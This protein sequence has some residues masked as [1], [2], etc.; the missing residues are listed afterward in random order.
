M[1]S[2]VPLKSGLVVPAES[3]IEGGDQPA[4]RPEFREIATTR[5]GRDIT[6]G[7]VDSLPILPP[8][9]RVLQVRGG[10]SY[11]LY[12]EVLRD[13]QVASTFNQRGLA[14]VSREWEV[15]PGGDRPIDIAAADF[16]EETLK[17]IR[18]DA[19]TRKMLFGIFYGFAVG[20]C[21]WARDGRFVVLDEIKVRKQRRFAFTPESELRLLT[22]SN[23]F[24]E[25][26]PPRKFWAFATGSDNDDDPYGLGLAHWLYWPVFFKR[27]GI[28]FW[29]IF[30]EKFGQPTA[31][32]KYQGSA[33]A[34]EKTRLLQA[35][36][37]IM[38]D[39]GIT[40]PD[41]MAIELLEAAR[42][43]TADY[44]SLYDRMNAAI[45]KVV[46]GQT[47]T[48]EDG[49]SRSQAEVHMDVRQDLVKADADLICD[50]LNCGPVLWLTQ[51]NFPDAM[52]PKVWR[53]IEEPEDLS[54]QAERDKIIFEMGFRPSLQY[55]RDTYGEGW[56]PTQPEGSSSIGDALTEF[57]EG[58]S[59]FPDQAT[60][61]RALD[62]LTDEALQ[63]QAEQLLKPIFRLARDEPD[64]LLGRLADTF[65]DIGDVELQ[66]L[67]ARVLFIA[68]TWG[69]LNGLPPQVAT[70]E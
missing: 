25:P 11:E 37:A 16:L 4:A 46:V 22:S 42:S 68:E 6:R 1:A 62:G 14:V 17:H 43:G 59:R 41:G 52:P 47:M 18:F 19:I 60:L 70:D 51:W 57:A 20:E 30:L 67:T 3:F 15:K 28:K 8:T 58:L 13:D 63:Q 21:L 69:R 5:D 38:V 23:P 12:E 10:G 55:I 53:V 65:P 33:T 32:G 48:T 61:E 64:Q 45:S 56:E 50:S 49:S 31:V 39:S 2:Y 34:E 35:L 24:G 27:N 66:E 54:K 7:Y 44:T 29:L 26:L 36:E 9:D 40:I